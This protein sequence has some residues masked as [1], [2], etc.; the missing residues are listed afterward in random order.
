MRS[1]DEYDQPLGGMSDTL[2]Q[3]EPENA[4]GLCLNSLQVPPPAGAG[5]G[6]MPVVALDA[7]SRRT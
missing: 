3:P 2:A 5:D 1:E 4:P 7:Q 6:R